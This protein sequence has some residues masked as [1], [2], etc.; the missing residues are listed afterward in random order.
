M[1]VV[2][3]SYADLTDGADRLY[4][5]EIL[6]NDTPNQSL[7]VL[8]SGMRRMERLGVEVIFV[9]RIVGPSPPPHAEANRAVTSSATTS[10]ALARK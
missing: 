8:R 10:S 9:M 7:E 4:N 5:M 1:V 3:T 6:F 2:A